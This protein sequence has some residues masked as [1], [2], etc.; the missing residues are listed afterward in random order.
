MRLG[1]L[2]LSLALGAAFAPASAADA[3]EFSQAEKLVFVEHQLANIK[4][5]TSLRY[6]FT[7]SGSLE[8]AFEDEVFVEVSRI[9]AEGSSVRTDF[10]SG[11]R[12]LELPAIDKARANPVVLYFLE[13][14]IREMARLT[15]RKTSNYFRNRI[16]RTL[17]TEAQVRDTTI[18]FEGRQLPA[19]E[20]TLSPYATDPARSR[21]E[22]YA[23]KSYTFVLSKEVP[24]GVYK[25]HTVMRA[26][27]SGEAPMLEEVMTLSGPV[28]R[29]SASAPRSQ[30]NQPVK[31]R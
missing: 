6:T 18:T 12:K 10:L 20:V 2:A 31:T 27:A 25:M 13:H 22:R 9:E 5:P 26:A 28:T 8:P 11:S 15:N 19:Q 17:V 14:D 21:Y 30:Q 16:R 3:S 7:R 4:T 29:R 24:G 23:D 1:G